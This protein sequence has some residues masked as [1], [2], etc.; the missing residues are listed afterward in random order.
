MAWHKKILISK[1]KADEQLPVNSKWIQYRNEMIESGRIIKWE[2][3]EFSDK[4]Y[5]SGMYATLDIMTDSEG[6]MKEIES[7]SNKIRDKEG[8]LITNP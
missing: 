6:T 3:S 4:G 5:G 2:K 1:V 8:I 7:M